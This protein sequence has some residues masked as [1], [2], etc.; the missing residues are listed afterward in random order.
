MLYNSVTA[1]L[2]VPLMENRFE[3]D[4]QGDVLKLVETQITSRNPPNLKGKHIC[5]TAQVTFCVD[6]FVGLTGLASSTLQSKNVKV[7][8]PAPIIAA[9]TGQIADVAG[10]KELLGVFG[11]LSLHHSSLSSSSSK[12]GSPPTSKI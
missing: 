10:L 9:A 7:T 11:L 12:I 2:A 5:D 3:Q 6:H 8:L 4:N 1:K